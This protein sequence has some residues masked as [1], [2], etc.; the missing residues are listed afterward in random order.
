MI[1]EVGGR[2]QRIENRLGP[3]DK[4]ADITT[5]GNIIIQIICS[6]KSPLTTNDAQVYRS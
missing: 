2:K 3:Q 6:I 5:P 1:S 4:V